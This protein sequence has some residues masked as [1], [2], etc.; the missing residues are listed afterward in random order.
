[1]FPQLKVFVEQNKPWH[2]GTFLTRP[3][4]QTDRHNSINIINREMQRQ[5]CIEIG[6][7][8]VLP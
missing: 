3:H 2:M 1:M 8:K 6:E 4:R 5:K 7:G